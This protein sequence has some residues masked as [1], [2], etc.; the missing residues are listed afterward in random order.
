MA[1][2]GSAA[3]DAHVEAS[4]DDS[5]IRDSLDV[6]EVLAARARRSTGIELDVSGNESLSKIAAAASVSAVG[7]PRRPRADE[8]VVPM[9]PRHADFKPQSETLKPAAATLIEGREGQS[10]QRSRADVDGSEGPA[11]LVVP[12]PSGVNSV[13]ACG[14]RSG[15]ACGASSVS[16]C[17]AA[18]TPDAFQ[19]FSQEQ[20]QTNSAL[21]SLLEDKFFNV[22]AKLSDVDDRFARQA[23][24]TQG[25]KVCL[26]DVVQRLAKL[27]KSNHHRQ[28]HPRPGRS[29][30]QTILI[31]EV[32]RFL[33]LLGAPAMELRSARCH[34]VLTQRRRQTRLVSTPRMFVSGG[35]VK[36]LFEVGHLGVRTRASG[37]ELPR[38]KP[39]F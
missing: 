17:G 29:R 31:H 13:S 33:G 8:V 5:L 37:S 30:R 20:E 27:E 4:V 2:P 6:V 25:N 35:R 15:S 24:A 22:E 14:A 32:I 28:L 9:T 39:R 23:N 7:A 36:S 21:A 18:A 10:P 34:S 19:L 38:T 16:A 12:Q 3:S 11:D 26:T 1:D